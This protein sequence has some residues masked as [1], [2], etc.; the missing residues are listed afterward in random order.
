MIVPRT[1][2]FS[3]SHGLF[4]ETISLIECL[5]QIR[6]TIYTYMYT[7]IYQGTLYIAARTSSVQI[8]ASISLSFTVHYNCLLYLNESASPDSL[9]NQ[10]LSFSQGLIHE[11]ISLIECLCQKRY[12]LHVHVYNNISR[13]I[14][15]SHKDQF[16]IMQLFFKFLHT[17]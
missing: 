12:N 16:N 8:Q 17:G 7:I 14:I 15:Y 9:V 13:Y 4:H 5:Y 6:Y 1:S 10:P 11:T 2:P 3:Y